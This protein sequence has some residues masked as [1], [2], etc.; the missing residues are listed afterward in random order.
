MF[1]SLYSSCVPAGFPSPADDFLDQR[2]DLNEFLV[3]HP[4]ATFFV[5][6][7]GDSMTG[8]GIM[9]G[10]ILIVDRA[11]EPKDKSVVVALVNGEFTVKRISMRPG[12]MCLLAE[13]EHYPAIE[14]TAQ[15][16]FEIWGVVKHVIHSF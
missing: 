6:V 7:K 15:M 4:S 13:N 14:I 3:E 1:P 8:A 9:S 11:F 16:D 5:R 2:L 12:K 10:D